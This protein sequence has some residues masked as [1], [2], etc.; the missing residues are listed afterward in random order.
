MYDS[1]KT[2][3]HMTTV[4]GYNHLY[5]LEWYGD[6]RIEEFSIKFIEIIDNLN[7][8]ISDEAKRDILY[9]KMKLSKVLAEDLAHYRRQSVNKGADFTL[10]FLM[11][12]MDRHVQLKQEEENVEAQNADLKKGSKRTDIAADAAGADEV[13]RKKQ[14]KEKATKE[15]AKKDEKKKVDAAPATTTD[16]K[17]KKGLCFFFQTGEC[18]N[19]AAACT[20]EHRKATAAEK[21]IL[22]KP[23]RGGSPAPNKDR[24]RDDKGGNKTGKASTAPCHASLLGKKCMNPNC[25][26]LHISNAE[27]M[28]QLTAAAEARDAA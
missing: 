22:A 16:K 25:N 17:P 26:F 21:A 14:A 15:K 6:E 1:F 27:Y 19:T 7:E 23:V 13:K 18:K 5:E 10:D 28:K 4:Y 12:S 24:K 3:N 2:E 11:D 20:F 9:K 8:T